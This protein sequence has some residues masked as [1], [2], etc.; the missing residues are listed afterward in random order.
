MPPQRHNARQGHGWPA[1]IE[2]VPIM[3]AANAT[4]ETPWQRLGN[5]FTLGLRARDEAEWLREPDAFGDAGRRADQ[6]AEKAWLLDN[7]HD[8]VFAAFPDSL[9]AGREV[10]GMV[11]TTLDDNQPPPQPDKPMHPLETAARMVP[12]D[13]LLLAPRWREG[14]ADT[15]DW[16]LVAAALAFP[17]HWVLA[18]KMGRPLAGI[19]G[20]VPHYGELLE[21]PMDRFFSNMKVGPVSHRW[22]WSVVTTNRLFTPHRMRRTPLAPGAGI[23]EIFIRMESQTLRKLAQ[24]GHVLFTIRTYVEPLSRWAGIPGALGSLA[25]M[26]AGMTPQMRDYKGVELYEDALKTHLAADRA[27]VS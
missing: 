1:A 20:P 16:V 12:E 25:E 6:I 14:D 24:T 8:E 26:L 23:D 22:N 18:E 27:R 3:T 15:L 17:A 11:R 4:A 21:R 13:L 2:A 19:H 7:R 5:R 9:D 10:L